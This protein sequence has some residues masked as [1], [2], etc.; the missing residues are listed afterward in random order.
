MRL[1][2]LGAAIAAVSAVP[3]LAGV[4]PQGALKQAAA[5]D[6]LQ[7]A[8]PDVRIYREGGQLSRIYGAPFSTGIS[9]EDSFGV[10]LGNYGDA[11]GM[12]QGRLV[13]ERT[14]PLMDGKFIVGQYQEYLG[15]VPVDGAKA[16]LLVKDQIGF[17]MVLAANATQSVRGPLPVSR[18]T[19]AQAVFRMKQLR[20][21]YT[22]FENPTKV[23][24]VGETTQH[25]AWRFHA[26]NRDSKNP[27]RVLAYV[28]AVSGQ[29]LAEKPALYHVDITGNVKGWASPGLKPDQANN[30]ETLQNMKSLRVISPTNQAFTDANGNFVLPNA[31][32]TA[33]DVTANLIGRWVTVNNNAGPV[34]ALTQNVTPPGPANFTFNTGMAGTDTAQING[35]IQ[36]TNVHDFADGINPAYPGIDISL[37]C[38][39]NQASTCNAFYNGS[40]INFYQAGGG[41]PNTAYSSVVW[42]EYGH[43]I[44]DKGH[45]SAAGD[46]HEGMADVTASLLG[47]TPCLGE[48]FRGQG[49]GCLRNAINGVNYPCSGP[50]HTC[51]QVI[52]GC[53]WLT[54][55]QLDASVGHS[56]GL[57]LVRQW[58]LNSILIRPTGITPQITID[59]LTLDDDDANL[60]N[61]TPHYDEINAGFSAKNMPAPPIQWL[62]IVTIQAPG[63]IVPP[64][65]NE[66]LVP[67]RVQIFD[68]VGQL[69]HDSVRLHYRYNGGAWTADPMNEIADPALFFG[70][71]LLPPAGTQVDWYVSAMDTGGHTVRLPANAP[72]GFFSFVVA[73]SLTTIFTDTFETNLGWG[74]VNT[75]L[76]TGAWVRAD[77]NGTF[78]NSA[79]A[80]P[81]NDSADPGA[82]CMFTGQAAVGGGPGDQ[83]VDGGPTVL[84][85]PNFAIAGAD[86]LFAYRRWFFNDDGDDSLVVQVSNNGG[87]TWVTV[88]TV[89]G[90]ANSWVDRQFRVGQYVSPT[91][92]VLVRFSTSDNPNNSV[93]E[94][95][96]DNV[97][98]KRINF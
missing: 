61:G 75:A 73:T 17:P 74:V 26:E 36:T 52:S 92:T 82:Q 33:V 96:I 6:R 28:D 60:G 15:N 44:V 84:T 78:L 67:V 91:N 95:A 10:F 27:A 24:F 56:T 14:L 97:V 68:N 40:S 2:W 30:P 42:H 90:A 79:P 22:V 25:L 70:G 41:C 71:I 38:N 39:V 34:L 87:G 45:P 1:R 7:S 11:F 46:Y 58:Y 76:T 49:T 18:L 86:A 55:L 63:D 35:F 65:Q 80:N 89:M 3:A 5:L 20:P 47:D 51:G 9:A 31:G 43:F 64:S 72:T 88:E 12:D 69:N 62:N 13:L 54:L 59:V 8:T 85:S 29:I 37:P 4:S 21:I 16:T 83:D 94:A 81:E 66:E 23:V 48:D 53:F 50:V 98:V 93:T 19:A 32:S 77:P 57:M